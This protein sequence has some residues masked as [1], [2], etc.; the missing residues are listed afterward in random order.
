MILVTLIGYKH[1]IHHLYNP[2]KRLK[3][4]IMVLKCNISIKGAK[5]PKIKIKSLNTIFTLKRKS[6][7]RENP[8]QLVYFTER[9]NNDREIITIIYG[10]SR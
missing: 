6:H 7:D 8:Y 1:A 4:I 5:I 2:Q 9:T 3:Q 10:K